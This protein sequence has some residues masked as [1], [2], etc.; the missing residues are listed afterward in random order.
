MAQHPSSQPLELYLK[1]FDDPLMVL[2]DLLVIY[3]QVVC[4]VN[5]D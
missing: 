1:L 2:A 4:H 3:S 5:W